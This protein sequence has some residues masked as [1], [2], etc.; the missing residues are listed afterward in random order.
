MFAGGDL[1]QKSCLCNRKEELYMMQLGTFDPCNVCSSS[2]QHDSSLHKSAMIVYLIAC[3]YIYIL[4]VYPHSWSYYSTRCKIYKYEGQWPLVVRSRGK[5][6]KHMSHVIHLWK[7]LA[8]KLQ[9]DA[10][11]L[12]N[13]DATTIE[14]AHQSYCRSILT[15]VL[16]PSCVPF[17]FP[18]EPS[19]SS[20]QFR[21]GYSLPRAPLVMPLL[22]QQR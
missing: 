12:N 4:Y 9:L 16:F 20:A 10:T 7:I 3:I 21:A 19:A 8:L 1:I 13:F 11:C 14:S 22:S 5:K 18:C 6:I 17:P 2:A 15:P